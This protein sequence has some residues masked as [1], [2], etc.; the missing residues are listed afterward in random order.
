M[1]LTEDR[2]DEVLAQVRAVKAQVP[3]VDPDAASD[4]PDDDMREVLSKRAG[5]DGALRDMLRG[6]GQRE[7]EEMVALAW[8]GR[9][10]YEPVQWEEALADV[11]RT[12]DLPL[13]DYLLAMPLLAEFVADAYGQVSALSEGGDAARPALP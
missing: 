13:V 9:G 12:V 8:I 11:G 6:L 3:P 2:L 4:G 7:L 5:S 1:K 10:D